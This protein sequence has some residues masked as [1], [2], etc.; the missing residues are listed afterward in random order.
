LDS[1]F[2][3]ISLQSLNWSAQYRFFVPREEVGFCALSMLALF[4]QHC[5]LRK[6]VRT[7]EGR[8]SITFNFNQASNAHY[9]LSSMQ[10]NLDWYATQI[11]MSRSLI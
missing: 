7:Y 4:L 5:E 3:S 2:T 8:T 6:I 11:P 1:A 9:F 10:S